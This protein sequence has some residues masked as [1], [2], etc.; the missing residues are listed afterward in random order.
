MQN[1]SPFEHVF[2]KGKDKNIAGLPQKI[3]QP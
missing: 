1:I 2:N 3:L